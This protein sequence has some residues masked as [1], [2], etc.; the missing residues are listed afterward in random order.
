MTSSNMLK[1]KSDRY[2]KKRWNL[3]TPSISSLWPAM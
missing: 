1:P 3:L 2:V